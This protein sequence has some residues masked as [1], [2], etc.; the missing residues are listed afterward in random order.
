MCVREKLQS[1]SQPTLDAQ[2]SSKMATKETDRSYRNIADVIWIRNNVVQ[3]LLGHEHIFSLPSIMS[4]EY[5]RLLKKM[6]IYLVS[7]SVQFGLCD[8]LDRQ[9]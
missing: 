2:I 3:V 6:L 7:W 1:T 8:G 5:Q 4:F 9:K